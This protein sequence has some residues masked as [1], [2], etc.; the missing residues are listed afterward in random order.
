MISSDIYCIIAWWAKGLT[1]QGYAD[2]MYSVHE[3]H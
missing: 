3:G 2:M 1:L